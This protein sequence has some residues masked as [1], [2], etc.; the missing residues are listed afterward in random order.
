MLIVVRVGAHG[1]WW[2]CHAKGVGQ[3]VLINGGGV[4]VTICRGGVLVA[5]C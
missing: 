5:V 4:L 3:G 2:R 1:E